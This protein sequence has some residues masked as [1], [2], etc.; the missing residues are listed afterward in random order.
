MRSKNKSLCD[1]KKQF[2]N[3]I[4][5]AGF[6]YSIIFIGL[7]LKLLTMF[8]YT[9]DDLDWGS[10]QGLGRLHT[11]FRGY[12]GRYLGNLLVMALARSL[13]LKTLV[14]MLLFILITYFISKFID[15]QSNKVLFLFVA[16][17]S[18]VLMPRE[19]LAQAVVWT[20]GFSNY[21]PGSV[22]ILA[23]LAIVR[24]FLN[25][26][27][28][29][30]SKLFIV[31]VFIM[32]VCACLFMEFVTLFNLVLSLTVLIYVLIKFK[33]ISA[34]TVSHFLGTILG[35]YLMFQNSNYHKVAIHAGWYRSFSFNVSSM[36]YNLFSYMYKQLVFFNVF[37]NFT[38][39]FLLILIIVRSIRFKK[40]KILGFLLMIYMTIFTLVSSYLYV[41]VY[42]KKYDLI[43]INAAVDKA[44]IF[45]SIASVL[46]YI[47]ILLSVIF[48]VNITKNKVMG[49]FFTLGI[50]TLTLPLF[51]VS[52]IGPRCFMPMYI[53]FVALIGILINE[54]NLTKKIF[55]VL[56]TLFLIATILG[57]ARLFYVYT[58]IHKITVARNVVQAVE[59]KEGKT[60]ID[61]PYNIPHDQTYVWYWQPDIWH[62]N[63][64]SFYHI[65]MSDTLVRIPNSEFKEKYKSILEANNISM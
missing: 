25:K 45:G 21:V 52:P 48:F 13:V 18:L 38:L 8:P 9:A 26:N 55:I 40:S 20:A 47:A 54:L 34:I 56:S 43:H 11:F 59:V 46:F 23:Y 53:F 37:I 50:G 39:T 60:S 42:L 28:P 2:N 36:L 3:S 63:Y 14:M 17:A 5:I 1:S 62:E 49:I 12:N 41:T 10:A 24:K 58:P 19:I 57:F 4:L 31:P 29:K 16:G 35:M 61:I 7:F 33:K 51:F 32:A 22:F 30:I 64:K 65:P 6:I 44:N 27:Y 15:K